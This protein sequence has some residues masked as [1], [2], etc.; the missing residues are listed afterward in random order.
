MTLAIRHPAGVT[1]YE[2][3]QVA[4]K[5]LGQKAELKGMTPLLSWTL[6]NEQAIINRPSLVPLALRSQRRRPEG[7]QP[8]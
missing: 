1:D 4:K 7:Q 3:R 8:D 6:R 5:G 2:S